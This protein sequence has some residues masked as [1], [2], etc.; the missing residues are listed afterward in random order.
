MRT[1]LLL[2]AAVG[3][4]GCGSDPEPFPAAVTFSVTTPDGD[5]TKQ[6]TT[7]LA[8]ER[9]DGVRIIDGRAEDAGKDEA[10]G[11]HNFPP[12]TTGPG[13]VMYYW[14][15]LRNAGWRDG[16]DFIADPAAGRIAFAGVTAIDAGADAEGDT[17][18]IR[19]TV[20]ASGRRMPSE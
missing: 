13:I 4:A 7:F 8:V 14:T 12:H 10:Y 6:V 1:T 20:E 11:R 9:P 3:L 17:K 16:V 18:E 5:T 15:L 19:V 2:L